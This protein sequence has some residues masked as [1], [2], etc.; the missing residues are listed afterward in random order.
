MKSILVPCDFSKP[1][2]EAFRMAAN[3]ASKTSGTIT[4]VH[5][6]SEPSRFYTDNVR[7][8]IAG[9]EDNAKRSFE[10]MKQEYGKDL[11]IDFQIFLGWMAQSLNEIGKEKHIDLIVMGTSGASGLP[12]I[13]IGSNTERVV[14]FSEVPVLSV[15][16]AKDITLLRN[17]LLPTTGSLGQ[18][19]FVA[20]VKQ[21][22]DFLQAT[23][24]VLL[25]NTPDNFKS[26]REGNET[27]EEFVKHYGIRNYKLHFKSHHNEEEAILDFARFAKIDLITMAT[28]ARK[29]IAHLFFGSITEDV[30]NHTQDIPIWTY[31]IQK[32]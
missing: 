26:D 29:G 15:R 20:K 16:T 19:E 28:H 24:H 4:V 8:A 2:I 23:L 27:L 32:R 7:F 18:S 13:L 1:A 11:Q 17:I 14:R 25:I 3:I 10:A 9:L 6:I 21:L 30:I 31:S 22:Q 5:K 12:E